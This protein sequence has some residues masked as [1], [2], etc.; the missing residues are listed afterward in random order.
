VYYES[1]ENVWDAIAREK[2]LKGWTRRK[3]VELT[4]TLNAAFDD[5]LPE[6][7]SGAQDSVRT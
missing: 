7:T 3:K 2:Q 5:L 6:I 1:C 4:R